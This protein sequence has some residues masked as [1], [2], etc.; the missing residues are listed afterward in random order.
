MPTP[1]PTSNP[2]TPDPTYSP[3]ITA[4]PTPTHRDRPV[5]RDDKVSMS[6]DDGFVFVSVLENDT[7]APGQDLKVQSIMS[8][9]S[10][11]GCS[12]SLDLLEVVYLPNVGFVGTDSCVYEA[13]DLVPK[14]DTATL[15]IEVT[16]SL[17]D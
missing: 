5:V 3:T 10:N 15:T 4:N 2:I 1:S 6:A 7:P 11:G 12:P 16:D 9:A 17:L 13:C 14:C 8:Y